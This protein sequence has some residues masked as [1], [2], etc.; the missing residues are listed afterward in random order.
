MMKKNV[1]RTSLAV[2]ALMVFGG[3]AAL[4][5]SRTQHRYAV[6]TASAQTGKKGQERVNHDILKRDMSAM[7]NE[8]HQVLAMAFMQNI[9]TFAKTLSD[10]AQGDT[11]LSADFA[12]AAVSEI[13]R[14]FD[15][16]NTHHQ[17]HVKAMRPGRP[18]RMSGMTETDMRDSKLKA[19]IDTL[20]K[21]VQNYTLNSKQIATDCADVLKHL[22]EMSKMHRQ[23]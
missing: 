8:P 20:D 18:S 23:E 3:M 11:P 2:I 21:E 16:A 12:R 22:D 4:A 6:Q 10:Q 9:E 19:A 5:Q 17:E 13:I 1:Y 14:N 7:T 15:E